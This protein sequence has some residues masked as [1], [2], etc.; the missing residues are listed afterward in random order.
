MLIVTRSTA[1]IADDYICDKVTLAWNP[2]VVVVSRLLS[3]HKSDLE[4][5]LI[6]MYVYVSD[7]GNR[8]QKRRSW[9]TAAADVYTIS[10]CLPWCKADTI[11][12]GACL[13]TCIYSYSVS[14]TLW[15]LC[16]ATLCI[17][18]RIESWRRRSTFLCQK[19]FMLA[20]PKKSVFSL[21]SKMSQRCIHWTSG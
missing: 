16:I 7:G 15:L 9:Q 13:H 4:Y 12:S 2:G 8:V 21:S 14:T 6:F 17:F 1:A 20:L 5:I 3:A 11:K 19:T 10:S 18:T